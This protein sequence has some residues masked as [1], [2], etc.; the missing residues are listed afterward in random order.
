MS[1][2][3]NLVAPS[4]T[5]EKAEG[6]V[7]VCLNRPT[8]IK[9]T[10]PNGKTVRINGNAVD[11]KGKD[12]GVLPVGSY[13]MTM[14]SKEDW[15]AIQK[16]YASSMPIFA[17]GLIFASADT[18]SALDEAKDKAELRGGLEP[19]DPSRTHSTGVQPSEVI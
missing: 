12:M 16:K 19:I 9:F 8:G 7:M 15:E 18:A 13:G 3:Q 4:A 17:Q 14:I 6:Y 11:L 5:P 2:E 10:L 1:K